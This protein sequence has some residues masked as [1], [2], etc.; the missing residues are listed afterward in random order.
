RVTYEYYSG[1]MVERVL[2]PY[3][4]VAKASH[5]YLIGR[6]EAEFRLYRVSRFHQIT[7]MGQTF[8]RQ[9]DFD[10][11]T[12]WQEH[13]QEFTETLA[14]YP[15]TLRL[16][17]SRLNFVTWLVPGRCQIVE[18]PDANG[19]LMLHIRIESAELAQ[20]LVFGLGKQ[21]QVVE[22]AEL[23]QAVIELAREILENAT[24]SG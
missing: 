9:A 22:P 24:G 6:R 5:W 1:E 10:L 23:R 19:W 14:E 21:A 11:T 18:P 2:E 8:Q 13:L 20:M 12:Y 7:L 3:S 4:L 15:F 16:H 17:T